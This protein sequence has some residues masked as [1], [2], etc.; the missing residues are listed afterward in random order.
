MFVTRLISGIA[1]VAVLIA[2]MLAGGS[3]VFLATFLVAMIGMFEY[4]RA[5]GIEKAAPGIAGYACCAA[6]YMLTA[7]RAESLA[8]VFI[9]ISLMAVMACYVLQF[10]KFT[11]EQA[12]EAFLG[13]VYPGVM[14]SYVYRVRMMP[15]G[16][17]LVW[18]IFLSAWGCDTLAYCSGRL[19]GR[20]KMTPV[21]SPHKTVEG[22]VG[23]TLGAALLGFLFGM[24]FAD[25]L[26]LANPAIA[27]T[28][29][30]G[31]GALISQIGDLTASGIK[32]NHGI[33]DYG[34]L[35]P[36]HGG[37]MDRFD[38]VIFTAP[39]IYLALMFLAK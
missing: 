21:L 17:Y 29:S 11:I 23:G 16:L 33:K 10:P 2:V 35:I 8:Q 4:Y 34:H 27:C 38:S 32:R 26:S 28:L 6:F 25:R 3:V 31:I 12:A 24:V 14:M 7:H 18:L 37:I 39:A 19:F 36:G 9:V 20:H 5:V 1:L 22:A 13:V 15:D 30:C